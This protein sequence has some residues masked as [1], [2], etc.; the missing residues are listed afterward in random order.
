MEFA[1]VQSVIKCSYTE[2]EHTMSDY[3]GNNRLD[4]LIRKYSD[5]VYRIAVVRCPNQADA[6][7]VYQEVFIKLVHHAHELTTDEHIKAWLIKVTIN[8]CN[9]LLSRRSAAKEDSIEDMYHDPAVEERKQPESE[10][11][12]LELLKKLVPPEYRDVIYLFYFEDYSIKE[13]GLILNKTQTNVKVLLNRARNKLKKQ[14]EELGVKGY[15]ELA[16]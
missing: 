12:L 9:T 14:L 1:A 10:F 5:T 8:Q 6:E 4:E 15:G 16:N 7:D 13:I 11:I 2:K 3:T